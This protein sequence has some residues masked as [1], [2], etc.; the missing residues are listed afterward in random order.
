MDWIGLKV[1]IAN[2]PNARGCLFLAGFIFLFFRMDASL[3]AQT[4]TSS[5]EMVAFRLLPG[6]DLKTE[7]EK[8]VADNGWK[9]VSVVTCVGSLNEANLRFANQSGGTKIAGK[10]EIVSLT[11][12]LSP[13]GTHLHLAVSDSTGKTT[14]GHLLAGCPVYTTA[15]IVLAILKD[16]VFDR[17]TDPTYGFKELKVK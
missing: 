7:I 12:T 5:V 13:A 17:E 15:E 11:G 1:W 6:Q 9:A 3:L 4:K 14:G 10:L 8:K 2:K 16:Y